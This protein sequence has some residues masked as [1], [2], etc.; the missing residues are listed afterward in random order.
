[1]KK[2]LLLTFCF[3]VL[4]LFTSAQ[5]WNTVADIPSG[6]HHPVTW[7][8]DGFGYSVT[9]TNRFNQDTDD[10][11]RYDPVADLWATLPDFPG[12]S[13]G[14]AI[15]VAYN[16]LGYLGFGANGNNYFRDLWSYDPQTMQWTR[17]ADCPGVA[18]RH[19]AM[20]ANNGKIYVG[21]G[22]DRFGDLKDWWVYDIAN[23]SWSSLPDI[24]GLPRHHPFQFQAGGEVY[25]GMGHGGPNIFGDWYRWDTLTNNWVTMANFPG[26]ARVAGTQFS[27]QGFGYV[28]SGDGDNHDYMS[29]GEMWRYDPANDSWTQLPPHPGVSRWAPGSFVI[30]DTVYFFGGIN[31]FN[32]TAPTSM[33]SYRLNPLGIDLAEIDQEEYA[34]Y[35]N[36]TNGIINWSSSVK[37]SAV[38]VTD[39]SGRT[40]F[41]KDNPQS[42]LNLGALEPGVYFLQFSDDQGRRL[43][44]RE[45]IVIS[46]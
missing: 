19:P 23:D 24:P 1:M 5:A 39:A 31:R 41:A 33:Y 15:G 40:V 25:A 38:V 27:H 4:P 3:S 29:T 13:R 26:E 21:L 14:F 17:L 35:P 45:T 12:V 10:F 2:Y 34:V 37:F 9:G 16:G 46:D 20:I 22:N 8:I 18:R 28:L 32:Q 43:N 6:V 30:G 42:P 44:N 7:A 11:Y 36:P